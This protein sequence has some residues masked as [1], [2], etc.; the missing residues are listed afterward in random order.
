MKIIKTSSHTLSIWLLFLLFTGACAPLSS[1][2][3]T[4]AKTVL[5]IEDEEKYPSA[6]HPDS[7]CSYFYFL[8]GSHAEN[9]KRYS[10][11]EEAFEK[12]L[13]CDPDSR[14][15]LRRLPILLIRMARYDDAAKWLRIAIKKYPEELQDRLLLAR[16]YIRSNKINKAIELYNEL[17]SMSPDDETLYLRLGFLYSEQNQLEKAEQVFGRVLEIN[18]ESLFAH[19]YFAR[20]AV[21]QGNPEKA[22][23]WYKKTL[24]INWSVEL[25]LEFAGFYEKQNDLEK[26]KA[27]YRSILKKEPGELR[28]G[29]ALV[30]TLLLQNNEK[31]A[32]EVLASLR[33]NSEDPT[34]IDIITARLYLRSDKLDKAEEILKPMAMDQK[35]PEATYMLAVIYYE[36][37][38]DDMAMDLLHTMRVGDDK[39]EDSL[40]LQVRILMED[41]LD[42]KAIQLMKEALADDDLVSPNLYTLLASFYMERQQL[43]LCAALLDEALLKYPDNAQLYFEYG[44]LYEQNGS[45]QQAI[46][47]MEKVLEINPDHAEALNY[48]GYT[49]ADSNTNLDKALSY[50]QRSMALKPD[51]GYI[52][53]SLGWVYFRMGELDLAKKEILKALDLEPKDPNIHE[54]LGDI[55]KTQGFPREAEQAY[56]KAYELYQND[57]DK[58]RLLEKIHAVQ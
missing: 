56:K 5:Y 39:F 33:K 15:I 11:A 42:S 44:L 34:Q 8:W 28:A 36:Q 43:D 16:L 21:K 3:T 41:G 18:P 12:A 20:L 4:V 58:T 48:L 1:E 32:L 27:L 14:S 6:E 50:I 55:Y 45:R 30:H 51:N 19:L 57:R 53:D 49:W 46:A 24:A 29:L 38:K 37:D 40:Y 7:S 35:I 52:Q 25:V 47:A 13:I 9:N 31:N 54:H 23:L 17:I 22:E 26:M 2:N 10:E